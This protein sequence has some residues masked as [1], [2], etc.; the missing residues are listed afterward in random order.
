MKVEISNADWVDKLT[1]LEIKLNKITNAN[2]LTNIRQEM[3]S[4]MTDGVASGVDVIFLLNSKECDGLRT[5]NFALWKA[6]DQLREM[7]SKSLFNQE[8]IELARSV[9]ILNDQRANLKRYINES[10]NS[11]IVEEKEYVIYD[12]EFLVENDELEHSI[13]PDNTDVSLKEFIDE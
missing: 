4:L 6:E 2:K 5:V 3:A 13:I 11:I 8:Y 7:E 12:T 10:S 9:Y 1:I